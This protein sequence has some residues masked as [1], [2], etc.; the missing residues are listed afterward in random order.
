MPAF[1]FGGIDAPPVPAQLQ[2]EIDA[3]VRRF[4]EQCGPML[5]FAKMNGWLEKYR[6]EVTAMVLKGYAAGQLAGPNQKP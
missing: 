3:S 4:E 6:T 5:V 1:D 2:P